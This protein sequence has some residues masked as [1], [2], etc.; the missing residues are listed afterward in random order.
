MTLLITAIICT[1]N[2][3]DYIKKSVESLINQTM[4][5]SQYEILVIDNGSTD[6]TAKIFED[7]FQGVANLRYI[8][9]PV[10]GLSKARNTG[11]EHTRGEIIAYLDDDAIACHDWLQRIVA[12]YKNSEK[13]IGLLGGKIEPIWEADRPQWLSDE[14]VPSLT[15]LDWSDKPFELDKDT[16]IAGANISVPRKLLQEVGGFS[17]TLGRKG[18]KLLSNEEVLLRRQLESKGHV[19]YYDPAIS[20]KHHIPA[21]RVNKEWFVSRFYW[22]GVSK[23]ALQIFENS[24]GP[25]GRANAGLM[26]MLKMFLHPKQIMVLMTDP[27]DPERFNRKCRSMAGLGYIAGMLWV[28]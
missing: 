21:A 24:T 16:W 27:E 6:N 5:D 2:R 8:F 26:R 17:Q 18:K 13:S 7:E 11:L 15:V 20:V 19:S 23:A 4:D 9:E 28:A 14:L 25:A 3:A 22:Q 10:L 12:T 1:H